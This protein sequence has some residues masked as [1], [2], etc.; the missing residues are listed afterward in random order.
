Y[1]T[2][3]F[4]E[5]RDPHPLFDTS[6]YLEE[7]SDV[8]ASGVHPFLHFLQ[9]EVRE[10]RRANAWFDPKW[11]VDQ[12]EDVRRAGANPLIHY[13]TRGGY[14]GRLPSPS[15][16]L[17]AVEKAFGSTASSR[18]T[19]LVRLLTAVSLPGVDLPDRLIEI[20]A[21]KADRSDQHRVP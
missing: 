6:W 16:P 3:G 5:G 19:P 14:E 2:T 9:S 12:Y 10:Y 20:L 17:Q 7:N 18:A 15:F 21:E 13:V 11:Y 4:A 8:A 1:L